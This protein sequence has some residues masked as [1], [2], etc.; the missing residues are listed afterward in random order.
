MAQRNDWPALIAFSTA[1]L[2]FGL[3]LGSGV[4]LVASSGLATLLLAISLA[5]NP[6]GLP[7][8]T[9]PQLSVTLSANAALFFG[10]LMVQTGFALS[11]A[12]LAGG[13]IF[14]LAM[15]GSFV[16]YGFRWWQHQRAFDSKAKQPAER[17]TA[18]ARSVE[19]D[20]DRAEA[21]RVARAGLQS[22]AHDYDV[23]VSVPD[24]D[25]DGLRAHLYQRYD[26]MGGLADP[27][28]FARIDVSFQSL[29][30]DT[31][32]VDIRADNTAFGGPFDLARNTHAVNAL[33][34][35]LRRET[36]AESAV[37]RLAERETGGAAGG[38]GDKVRG[39][40]ARR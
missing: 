37:G 10:A 8:R 17:S 12:L 5:V 29:D 1:L 26:A 4:S 32:R 23:R 7:S 28:A 38:T 15:L 21:Q 16:S 24:D 20:V 11:A 2:L 40:Q 30:A 27:V 19:I 18:Q 9:Y 34:L 22:L 31:T 35:Y 3:L 13:T 6:H 33:A 25:A 14:A 39:S 36:R